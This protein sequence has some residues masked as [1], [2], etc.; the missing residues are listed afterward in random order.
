MS[1]NATAA[2]PETSPRAAVTYWTQVG[3]YLATVRADLAR[4]LPAAPQGQHGLGEE[5]R[6]DITE[7]IEQALL[8]ADTAVGTYSRLAAVPEQQFGHG[9][10]VSVRR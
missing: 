6:E 1:E 7:A 5:T 10:P 4:M 9:R 3:Q 8:A 2:V